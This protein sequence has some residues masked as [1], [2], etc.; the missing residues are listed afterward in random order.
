MDTEEIA[1][2]ARGQ[3]FEEVEGI[4]ALVSEIGERDDKIEIQD[5]KATVMQDYTPEKLQE[6]ISQIEPEG[7]YEF[8]VGEE[9]YTNEFGHE[10]F[11]VSIRIPLDEDV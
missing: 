8:E 5:H 11:W 9:V 4:S 6:L 1:K 3:I 7:D 2:Q 10:Y